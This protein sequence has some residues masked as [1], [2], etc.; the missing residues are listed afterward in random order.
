MLE[1]VEHI[2]SLVTTSKHTSLKW[3]LFLSSQGSDGNYS[4]SCN[5]RLVQLFCFQNLHFCLSNGRTATSSSI[6]LCFIVWSLCSHFRVLKRLSK[7]LDS[8]GPKWRHQLRILSWTRHGCKHLYSVAITKLRPGLNHLEQ[9]S[10]VHFFRT[11][12]TVLNWPEVSIAL[13]SVHAYQV[14]VI[15]FPFL[16]L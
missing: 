15:S 16:Y 14:N 4:H 10:R 11:L 5:H 6:P 12:N 2:R 3:V 7:L 13:I 1:L 8:S 9:M